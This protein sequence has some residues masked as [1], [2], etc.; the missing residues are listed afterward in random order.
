MPGLLSLACLLVPLAV[1]QP[2]TPATDVA[3]ERDLNAV[4]TPR[5]LRAWH[6]LFG[7]A[8]HIAGTPGDALV[9]DNLT[10]A[11]AATPRSV[12][13]HP[14]LSNP[15]A[16][17]VKSEYALGIL[18]YLRIERTISREAL[19]AAGPTLG[20]G[21]TAEELDACDRAAFGLLDRLRRPSGENRPG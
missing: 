1:A 9:L 12:R 15:R 7:S 4:P 17:P 13:P 16:F 18:D 20:D 19:R 2:A 14:P 8:P 10:D 11:P 5:N 6:D 21:V 3:F